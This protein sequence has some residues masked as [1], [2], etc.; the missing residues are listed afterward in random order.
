MVQ[1]MGLKSQRILHRS[2]GSISQSHIPSCSTAYAAA[3]AL[4]LISQS[5]SW[6]SIRGARMPHEEEAEELGRG[7]VAS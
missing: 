3:E 4:T 1:T 2:I 7:A 6:T 5:W